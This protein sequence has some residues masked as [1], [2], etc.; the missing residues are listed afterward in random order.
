M[1]ALLISGPNTSTMWVP[2]GLAGRPRGAEVASGSSTID[3]SLPVGGWSRSDLTGAI[4][5]AT[6][7]QGGYRP[8]SVAL[9]RSTFARSLRPRWATVT[10]IV[11]APTLVGLLFLLVR[12]SESFTAIVRE[13]HSGLDVRVHG[14]IDRSL[15]DRLTQMCASGPAPRTVVGAPVAA[16]PGIAP[17]PGLAH[18]VPAMLP[19]QAAPSIADPQSAGLA[20]VAPPPVYAGAMPPAFAPVPSPFAGGSPAAYAP[21]VTPASAT[22]FVA[23]TPPPY[24]APAPASFAG[25]VPAAPLPDPA[26]ASAPPPGAPAATLAS[27]APPV[28]NPWLLG[29]GAGPAEHHGHTQVVVRPAVDVPPVPA[30]GPAL[31]LRLPDG[32][33]AE[34]RN[35]ALLGR[36]PSATD[37]DGDARLLVV[38]DDLV[39]KTHLAIGV[40]DGVAWVAD[41]HSTNGSTLVDPDGREIPLEPGQRIR[42]DVGWALRLGSSW[43][44]IERLV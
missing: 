15:L 22:S 6:V 10:A 27:H 42:I 23:G 38:N 39:S 17:P 26:Y 44:R 18:S 43:A 13:D 34:V 37:Q 2:S 24:V 31:T 29:G 21:P 9:D 41:R 8:L 36:N 16:A 32:N 35:L 11:T 1:T 30:V 3:R 33:T 28:P 40:S 25:G 5:D 4:H 14:C 20:G 19:V 7:G 12:S